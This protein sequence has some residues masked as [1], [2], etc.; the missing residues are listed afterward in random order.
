M[1]FPWEYGRRLWYVM[2]ERSIGVTLLGSTNEASNQLQES[3]RCPKFFSSVRKYIGSAL[4]LP[5]ESRDYVEAWQR[6]R[7]PLGVKAPLLLL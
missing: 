2:M 1:L 3:L 7:F 6:R 4:L 5:M